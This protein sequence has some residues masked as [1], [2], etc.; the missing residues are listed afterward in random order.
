M[1]LSETVAEKLGRNIVVIVGLLGGTFILFTLLRKAGLLNPQVIRGYIE[2][3]GI[4]APLIFITII[5]VCAVSITIPSSPFII[6]GG[7]IFGLWW[8]VLYSWIGVTIGA[9]FAFFVARYFRGWILR[10]VGEHAELLV[11]FHQ[12][13]VAWVIFFTRSVPF[14]SFEVISYAAGL[15]SI[16]YRSYLIA[17]ALGVIPSVFILVTSGH[18]LV[19]SGGEFLPIILACTMILLIFIVPVLID[20]YNPFGWKE[21]LLK[22]KRLN[23]Q[24]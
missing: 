10:L 21:K 1:E 14:F 22:A 11:R 6:L 17:T 19:G 18:L 9:T 13:Y 20:H 7:S 4:W 8:G 15:T 3:A 5:A 16:S 24:K 2:S 23:T 12:K